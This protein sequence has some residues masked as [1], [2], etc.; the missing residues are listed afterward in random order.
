MT[1]QDAVAGIAATVTYQGLKCTAVLDGGHYPGKVKISDKRMRHLEERVLDRD[2]FHG[3]WNYA[4]RPA[5]PEPDPPPGPDLAALAALAGIPDLGALLAAVTAPWQADRDRRLHLARGA[6]RTRAS[7]P[8]A[9]WKLPFEA[10]VTAA[11]CHHRLGMPYRLLSEV[12]GA[13]EPP[14]A[15]PSPASTPSSPRTA[16]PPPPPNP[17]HHPD[18]LRQHA[19]AS[20]SP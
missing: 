7:G 3:Q 6:P 2:P 5:P 1:R 8:A 14:S 17:H 20:A 12:L 18:P 11:A 19:T 16:S 10:I 4:V 13:H 9:P 15:P